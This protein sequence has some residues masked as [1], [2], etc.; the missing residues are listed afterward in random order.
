MNKIDI[1]A[2]GA[3]PDDVELAC[4]GT[5]L[6]HIKLGKLVG[7]ADLTRGELGTRGNA[8]IREQ[9]AADAAAK[10]GVVFRANLDMRDGFFE[11]N[12]V[13][14]LKIIQLIR[15]CQPDIVLAN[16]LKDRHCDHGRAARLV[17]ESCFLSGLVKIKTY[18]ADGRE[19]AGWRPS[20]V[21]HYIQ[22]Y[23]ISPDF[24]VDISEFME[25]K[26]D[27][28]LAFKSQFYN[29]TSDEPETPISSRAF[30]DNLRGRARD[31]G[32]PAGFDFAE[33]FTT[34]RYIG[35]RNLFDL[36]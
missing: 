28:V 11:H 12:D 24:V 7:I 4:A 8:I 21:Y 29:P 31:F 18:D 27:L 25:A 13:N 22:D 3:H 20:A 19:Q 14:V 1:L 35:V 17:A 34:C 9:E 23:H 10:M 5:L 30:L 6:R 26:L 16:A 36:L 15:S 2:F 33:G 32:R